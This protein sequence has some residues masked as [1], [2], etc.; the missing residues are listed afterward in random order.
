MKDNTKIAILLS[1]IVLTLILST[2]I[3]LRGNDNSCNKCEI[4]FRMDQQ[5][6]IRLE[7]P[8]ITTVKVVDLFFSLENG[9]CLIKWDRVYGYYG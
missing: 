5:S 9:Q 8:K 6:G 1:C 7:E 3:Y 4:D 2:S